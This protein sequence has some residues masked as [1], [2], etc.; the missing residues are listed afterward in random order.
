[1]K[2]LEGWLYVAALA[3]LSAVLVVEGRTH[4][5]LAQAQPV[6]P[7]EL[8][9]LLGNPQLK[10]QVVDLR[11]YD[12]DHFLDTHVPG[13]VPLPGCDDAQAPAAARERVYPYVMTVLVTDDGDEAA[14]AKCRERFSF[15]RNLAGG[16]AAWS[17]ATLPE[18][19]GDYAAPKA[20]A[21]GGCL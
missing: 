5:R 19:T 14:F 12:D 1:V 21:G 10:V 2:Q 11:A 6:T 7:R 13:A 9:A 15:A 8:Y 3:A 17:D 16:M 18:D 4:A 20:G